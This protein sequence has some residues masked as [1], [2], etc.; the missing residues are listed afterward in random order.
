M[1]H[2]QKLFRKSGHTKPTKYSNGAINITEIFPTIN[3]LIIFTSGQQPYW[4]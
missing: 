2:I 1:Y 4:K 3:L